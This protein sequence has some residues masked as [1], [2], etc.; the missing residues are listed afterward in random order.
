ML[1]RARFAA[2]LALLMVAASQA[3]EPA[4]SAPQ[5]D[6]DPFRVH[7]RMH[8]KVAPKIVHVRG[9]SQTGSGVIIRSDGLI[10]TSPT[11]CGVRSTEA[12]VILQGNRRVKAQVVGRRIDLEL[13]LLKIDAKDLPVMEF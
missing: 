6:K 5:K 4:A 3:Q 8:K 7:I 12:T 1:V 11:A 13:A 2:L 10:L 9:G